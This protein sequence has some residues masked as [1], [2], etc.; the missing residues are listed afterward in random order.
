MIIRKAIKTDLEEILELYQHLFKDENYS[1]VNSFKDKWNEIINTDG[2]EYFVT[3]VDEK[4]VSSCN[5][6]VIPNFSRNQRSYA[7]I[8][9][10]ITHPDYR[11]KG[12][13]RSIIETAINHA[14]DNN[15]YKV[16]LLS[17]SSHNRAV[18]HKFYEELGFDG[19]TKRGFNL[20]F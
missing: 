8:E 19:D 20:R 7:L 12:Y 18:A 16:M 6:M 9:N 4:I 10:V 1:D 17:T 11:R 13:G 14:K 15:C 3:L 2:L 5:I